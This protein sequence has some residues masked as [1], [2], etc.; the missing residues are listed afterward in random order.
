[1]VVGAIKPSKT[2]NSQLISNY[3]KSERTAH[4]FPNKYWNSETKAPAEVSYSIPA[5]YYKKDWTSL[6]EFLK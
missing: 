1:M 4:V 3:W 2:S 5:Y 6:D